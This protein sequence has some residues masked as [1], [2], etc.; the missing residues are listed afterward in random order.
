MGLRFNKNKNKEIVKKASSSIT[1][2]D[3]TTRI[4][5]KKLSE[6]NLLFLRS[7]KVL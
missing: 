6:N 7:L 1:K 3:K 2:A 5:T 4:N